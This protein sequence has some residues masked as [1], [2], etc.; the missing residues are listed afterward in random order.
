M[1]EEVVQQQQQGPISMHDAE[2]EEEKPPPGPY[3]V[4]TTGLSTTNLPKPPVR[5]LDGASPAPRPPPTAFAS[6][7][8]KPAPR[9]PPRLPPRQNSRPDLNTPEPPPS[10]NEAA[11]YQ[12]PDPGAL[13]R[14]GQ[15]GISVPGFDIGRTA[16][17][18][19]PPPRSPSATPPGAP[20]AAQVNELQARFARITASNSASSLPSFPGSSSSSKTQPA[21]SQGTTWEQKQASMNTARNFHKDPSSVSFSDARGAASTANNFR[22]RHGE[23]VSSGVKTAKDM[24]SKYSQQAKDMNTKY[25]IT[26]KLSGYAS[27]AANYNRAAP[28]SSY[29]GAPGRAAVAAPA[30]E[31]QV[32]EPHFE[33]SSSSAWA[34]ETPVQ[35][36]QLA[37]AAGAKKAPPPPPKKRE[38]VAP[39]PPV[40]LSSKPR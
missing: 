36:P 10:Y 34:A 25:G 12:A 32:Q 35:T 6:G 16:S 24:S 18:P 23:Q 1:P 40:P 27:S 4:D 8:P 7:A 28:A 9:L 13:N 2:E 26:G 21:P 19:K 15:S 14:L 5:R 22:E 17:P 11:H 3:R 37:A 30:H 29:A 31:S 38:L 33:A 20:Q 39:P